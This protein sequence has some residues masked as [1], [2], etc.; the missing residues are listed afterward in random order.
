MCGIMDVNVMSKE[1]LKYILPKL[2][3]GDASCEEVLSNQLKYYSKKDRQILEK[4]LR[5]YLYKHNYLSDMGLME[6]GCRYEYLDDVLWIQVDKDYN[7]Y[8]SDDSSGIIVDFDINGDVV[9]FEILSASRFFKLSIE[10]MENL[11]GVIV[12]VDVNVDVI[13]FTLTLK[14]G[15]IKRSFKGRLLN[16]YGMDEGV[17]IF[18]T[19]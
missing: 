7:Y 4:N 6:I 9:A 3:D 13:K 19:V 18:K 17:Y 10:E 1:I 5:K 8:V 16:E 15:E 14:V 11:G 12:N 2:V